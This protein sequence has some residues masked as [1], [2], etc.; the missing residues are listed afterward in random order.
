MNIII[1]EAARKLGNRFLGVKDQTGK[2]S[3]STEVIGPGFIQH[4][5]D[6]HRHIDLSPLPI[7]IQQCPS[8]LSSQW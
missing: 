5:P 1:K 6:A 8:V 4:S 7:H 3:N 2:Q